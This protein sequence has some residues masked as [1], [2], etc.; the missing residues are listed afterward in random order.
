MSL[1]TNL[2]NLAT[3]IA[4]QFKAITGTIGPL[5]SL[6]TTQK[7][8]VVAAINEVNAKPTSAG[9]PQINDTVVSGTTVYSS[10]KTNSE[11]GAALASLAGSAPATLDT[12]AELAT[13]LG[14]DPNFATTT[15]T[16]LGNRVR[17]DTATQGLN[18]TQ[19]SNART[20]IDAAAASHS[21]P[22][23]DITGTLPAARLPQ[24]TLTA[25]GALE[26]A[27]DAETATGTDTA[28]GVTPAGLRSVTGNPETDLVAVFE[29]GLV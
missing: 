8:S 3:R 4:T 6:T 16:S 23:G 17:T 15:A 10:Q 12:L 9:G 18:T 1:Q 27:T 24:A 26:L 20:N 5:A 28:R 14:E 21:H 25:I 2:S 29:A 11:I 19:R 13:A 7:S 22:V